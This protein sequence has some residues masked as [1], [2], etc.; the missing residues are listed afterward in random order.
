MHIVLG[1]YLLGA[2]IYVIW[3]LLSLGVSDNN[4]PVQWNPANLGKLAVYAIFWPFVLLFALAAMV[5]YLFCRK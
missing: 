1:I 2:V 3:I 5:I 4:Q